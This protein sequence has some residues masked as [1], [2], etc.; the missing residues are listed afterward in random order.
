MTTQNSSKA[1][2]QTNDNFDLLQDFVDNTSDIIL[3]LS[4]VGEFMFVNNA[5]LDLLDYSRAE[6]KEISIDDILHP[7]Y[8][9]SIK[10][11][12]EKIPNGEHD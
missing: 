3:M 1:E 10:S 8:I 9:E 11:D 7:Q 5:F 12:F 4:L 6:I 2:S